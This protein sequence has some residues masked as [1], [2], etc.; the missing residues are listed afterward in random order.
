MLLL[1]SFLAVNNNLILVNC[2][3]SIFRILQ[4]LLTAGFVI[5]YYE[6]YSH[7]FIHLFVAILWLVA[8]I[9]RFWRDKSFSNS[10]KLL[11]HYVSINLFDLTTF[12][13]FTLKRLYLSTRF[14]CLL[15]CLILEKA[16]IFCEFIFHLIVLYC[17]TSI[18]LSFHYEKHF[19]HF[20]VKLHPW[21]K[22]SG[23][24]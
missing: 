20:I 9:L 10:V 21:G 16:W 15:T 1:V 3:K 12:L 18:S 11:L 19:Q 2:K 24:S 7:S 5:N 13:S 8:N 17:L 6:I 22:Y 14:L 4:I 23:K